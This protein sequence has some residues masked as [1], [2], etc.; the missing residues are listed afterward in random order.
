MFSGQI[1]ENE[2]AGDYPSCKTA[3][4]EKIIIRRG[5]LVM[6]SFHIRNERHEAREADE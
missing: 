3:P 5:H 6:P 2:R 1:G 4:S